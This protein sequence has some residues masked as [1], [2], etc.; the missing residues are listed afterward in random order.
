MD[1]SQRFIPEGWNE[2]SKAFSLEELNEASVNGNIIEAKVTKCDSN[3]NLYLDLGNNITFTGIIDKILYKEENDKTYLALIDYKTGSEDI[4]LNYLNYGI[5]IQLPIYLYLSE[6]LDLPNKSYCGFYLQK[7]NIAK[8]DYRLIGYSN[9]NKDILSIIDSNY[10]NSKIIKGMKTLKDGS[11]SSYAKVLNDEEINQIKEKTK[12][13]INKAIH[14]IKNN[15]FDINPK[16]DDNKNI[17]CEYCQFKD[18]CFVKK[19]NQIKIYPEEFGGEEN[20]LD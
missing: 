3:Y 8:K 18:I 2:V 17:G 15:V 7:F 1:Y 5:N 9:S 11:F 13:Q 10:D 12:E 16:I 4:T 14:N 19:Q 20:G 6:Q